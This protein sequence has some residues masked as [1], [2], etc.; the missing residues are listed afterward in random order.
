MNEISLLQ[1]VAGAGADVSLTTLF[2]CKTGHE[3]AISE[4]L[5]DPGSLDEGTEGPLG[6]ARASSDGC[7][8]ESSRIDED[9]SQEAHFV[10]D[11][12]PMVVGEVV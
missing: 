2:C 9:V 1:V 3:S 8:F 7:L 11:K 6:R 10:F 4:S 12:L 5:Q